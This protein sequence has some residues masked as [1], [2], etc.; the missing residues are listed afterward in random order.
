MIA[1]QVSFSTKKE[2]RKLDFIK[3][4]KSEFTPTYPVLLP[5]YPIWNIKLVHCLNDLQ[6]KIFFLE[7]KIN[8]WRKPHCKE[9]YWLISKEGEINL[10]N[11]RQNCANGTR[12]MMLFAFLR[13]K[14]SSAGPLL[15]CLPRELLDVT[16]LLWGLFNQ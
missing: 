15:G 6:I 4:L 12:V 5:N 3:A 14:V 9:K 13:P 2:A 8:I 10:T 16:R 1:L 11:Q 7:D